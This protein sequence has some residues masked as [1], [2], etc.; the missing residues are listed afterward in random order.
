M[1]GVRFIALSVARPEAAVRAFTRHALERTGFTVLEAEDGLEALEVYHRESSRLDAIVLD[2][3]MPGMGG[4]EVFDVFRRAD[5]N[6]PV[7]FMSGS[8]PADAAGALDAT[9]AVRFLQKPYRS[10]AL[11]DELSQLLSVGSDTAR[12]QPVAKALPRLPAPRMATLAQCS[13][14]SLMLRYQTRP[15]C[16]CSPMWPRSACP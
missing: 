6:L 3:S 14:R 16:S 2:L 11:S 1:V 5:R 4:R 15:P 7:L 9:K 10:G 13:S 8:D 12:T